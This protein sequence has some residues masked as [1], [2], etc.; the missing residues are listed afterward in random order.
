MLNEIHRNQFLGDPQGFA[1]G[2]CLAVAAVL[3]NDTDE[4]QVLKGWAFLKE[5]LNGVA[6]RIGYGV[7]LA[8]SRDSEADVRRVLAELS[9]QKD[10][11]ARWHFVV[12]P[13]YKPADA[14]VVLQEIEWRAHKDVQSQEASSFRVIEVASAP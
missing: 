11:R 1:E 3:G 13:V 2:P 14:L 7:F 12:A 8:L 9:A 10:A 5:S 4:P 6:A